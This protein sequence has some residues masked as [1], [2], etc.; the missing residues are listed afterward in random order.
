MSRAGRKE[1]ARRE[2]EPSFRLTES[3]ARR[4]VVLF[5]IFQGQSRAVGLYVHTGCRD[6][7]EDEDGACDAPETALH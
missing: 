2:V 5:T 3:I 4:G 7:A 6:G 1:S